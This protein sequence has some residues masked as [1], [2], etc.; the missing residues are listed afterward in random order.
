MFFESQK[1]TG[2]PYVGFC[3]WYLEFYQNQP[4]GTVMIKKK[5]FREVACSQKMVPCNPFNKA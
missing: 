1:H 5:F 4:Q 2:K 3:G